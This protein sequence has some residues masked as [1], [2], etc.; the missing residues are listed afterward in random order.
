MLKVEGR[1]EYISSENG[2]VSC[3]VP[4]GTTGQLIVE[5]YSSGVMTNV[6]TYPVQTKPGEVFTD[7]LPEIPSGTRVKI[8]LWDDFD[9]LEPVM[10]YVIE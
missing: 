2:F 3:Y 5:M 4:N 9:N 7:K 6:K 8:I 10:E 1:V